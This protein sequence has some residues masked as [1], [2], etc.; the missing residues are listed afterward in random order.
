[1]IDSYSNQ[2]KFYAEVIPKVKSYSELA[3]QARGF[4]SILT[5]NPIFR[6][7]NLFLSSG[8]ILY[9]WGLV[10]TKPVFGVSD[11]ARLKPVSAL[12]TS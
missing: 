10:V 12:V 1:M 8:V 3:S 5:E 6:T 4:R 9:R 11:K 2:M 7:L